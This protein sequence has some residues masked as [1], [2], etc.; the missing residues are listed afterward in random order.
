MVDLQL[1][2]ATI[3][4]DFKPS[5]HMIVWLN[6]AIQSESFV[7][8][9]IARISGIAESS[10]Y[11]WVKLDGFNE[12]FTNEFNKKLK[13]QSWKL[14]IIGMKNAKKDFKYWES[15][16]KRVGNLLD[17]KTQNLQINNLVDIDKYIEDV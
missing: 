13:A 8:D 10:Y 3:P 2:N 15:M 17:Q 16:Q 11:R 6:T 7:I 1:Q 4:T 14:D 5:P 9:E 12:W